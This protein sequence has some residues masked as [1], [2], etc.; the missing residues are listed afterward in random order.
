MLGHPCRVHGSG[1][2]VDTDAGRV[3][4]ELEGDGPLVILAGG[5]PGVGHAHY[6]PWF[7]RLADRRTVAYVDYPGTG[8]S[9]PAADYTLERYAAALEGVRLHV[10]AERTAMVALS[11]GGL[12]ALAHALAYPG[13][14]DALVLSNAQVSA[15]TWQEGN[16]DNVN[17]ALREHDPHAWE[18]LLA[19]RAEG[20]T[21]LDPRYQELFV[22]VLDGLEWADPKRRPQLER[23]EA[24]GMRLD[25]YEAFIGADPEWEV[26]GAVSGFDPLP[27]LRELDMPVLVVG[28]RWDG[29]TTPRIAH[30]TWKAIGTL[31]DLALLDGSAHRPWAEEPEEYFRLLDEFLSACGC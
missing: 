24:E 18:E 11:F 22:D 12:P 7:S 4:I 2:L 1:E 17:R 13:A 3:Y 30:L 27:R 21:S 5:G 14:L 26:T 31:A 9:D 25:V 28:G 23:D 19:L 15:A 20:A 8:R 6:H 10:G 29:L 16:I